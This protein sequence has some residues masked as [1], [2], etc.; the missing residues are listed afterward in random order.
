MDSIGPGEIVGVI[1]PR[2]AVT[3]DTLCEQKSPVLLEA[4]EF[5]ETVIEMAIES[6][7]NAERDKLS[8]ILELLKRQDPTFRATENEETGQT[9]IAGMGELHLEVIK[10]RL[11]R[12][13]NLKVKVHKPRVSYRESIGIEK[14]VTRECNRLIEGQQI[15]GSVTLKMEPDEKVESGVKVFNRLPVDARNPSPRGWRRLHRQL[16]LGQ[17]SSH[18]R[19]RGSE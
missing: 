6:D 17:N 4:I 3:G 10:N 13:F 16:P 19:Q 5:P 15:F 2:F 18:T 1:G 14:T 9:L 7:S 12:D 8:E 11:L